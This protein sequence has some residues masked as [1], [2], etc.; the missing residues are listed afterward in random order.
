[1][2][3]VVP[4]PLTDEHLGKTFPHWFPFLKD[5]SRRSKEPVADLMASVVRGDIQP[6]LIWNDD[7]KKAAALLG[8][9]IVKRGDERIGEIVW[10]T[11]K[12][13]KQWTHLLPMVEQYLKHCGC[14]AVRPICRPGW[15]RMLLK[16]GYKTTHLTMEKVL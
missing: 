9:R 15:S 4:I 2:F 10:T 8:L 6:V 13:M 1:M 7:E 16:H 11:G 5:I 3:A 14:V 12:G